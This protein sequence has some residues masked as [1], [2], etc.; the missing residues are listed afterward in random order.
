MPLNIHVLS[1]LTIY[2]SYI[3]KKIHRLTAAHSLLLPLINFFSFIWMIIS[4]TNEGHL[5]MLWWTLGVGANKIA[6]LEIFC[7]NNSSRM[8][9][10]QAFV[11]FLVLPLFCRTIWMMFMGRRLCYQKLLWRYQE[12]SSLEQNPSPT[13]TSMVRLRGHL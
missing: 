8:T 9:C 3:E 11:K 10:K 6:F 2:S 5:N 7:F 4:N 13:P 12:C 1:H